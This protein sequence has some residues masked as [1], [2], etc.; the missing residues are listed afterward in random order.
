MKDEEGEEMEDEEGEKEGG[1]GVVI[2]E[3]TL[4]QPASV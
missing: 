4:P 1:E 2:E 3:H